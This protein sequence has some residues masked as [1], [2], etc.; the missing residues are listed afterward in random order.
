MFVCF[1]K[2]KIKALD[3][4][5]EQAKANWKARHGSGAI[6]GG[7]ASGVLGA[8]AQ[9]QFRLFDKKMIFLICQLDVGCYFV[10]FL[11]CNI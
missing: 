2:F 9:V 4:S 10:Q 3:S 5:I 11:C 1:P 7:G 6:L 8:G